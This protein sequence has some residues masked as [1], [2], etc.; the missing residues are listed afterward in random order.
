[1]LTVSIVV[2]MTPDG[3]IGV[4]NELPWHLPGD[5]WRFREITKG[6]AVLMGWKTFRS[7]LDQRGEP[8]K[9]GRTNLVLTQGHASEV[10][11]VGGLPIGN[12]HGLQEHLKHN[13]Y[14]GGLCVIGGAN[15][16]HQM[17]PY[18][19]HIY[20]TVVSANL[21]GDTLFPETDWENDWRIIHKSRMCIQNVRDEYP[22][23]F[24]TYERLRIHDTKP[25]LD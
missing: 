10:D 15:V 12:V 4:N 19:H 11:Q 14:I 1:M 24:L 3:V 23:Q 2:A 9:N 5:L 8:L 20:R 13:Q 16:Y 21:Q 6:K 7:I 22:T 17:L 25:L 18:T